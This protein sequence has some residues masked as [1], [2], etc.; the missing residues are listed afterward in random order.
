MMQS[1]ST[2]MFYKKGRSIRIRIETGFSG[3]YE[4]RCA[5]KKGRSIRI[6]IE[7]FFDDRYYFFFENIKK[8][9]PLE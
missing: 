8:E 7:T 3:E 2:K 9:D 5:D 1:K 6:R 4:H